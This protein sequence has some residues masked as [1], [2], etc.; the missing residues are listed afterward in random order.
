[1]GAYR[2]HIAICPHCRKIVQAEHLTYQ[3]WEVAR[4]LIDGQATANIARDLF[5]SI[6][7]IEAHR[8]KIFE[9]LDITNLPMLIR[10][11]HEQGLLQ[12][13]GWSIK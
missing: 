7:T 1:M 6:K 3:Q 8:Q 10:W 11:A 2:K 5:V 4:R 13:M 9:A 12:L